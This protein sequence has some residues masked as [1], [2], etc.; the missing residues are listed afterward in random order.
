VTSDFPQEAP[1]IPQKI[2]INQYAF[3]GI[4]AVPPLP[5][6]LISLSPIIL[7]M[8]SPWKKTHQ[9]KLFGA[10][11]EMEFNLKQKTLLPFVQF[12]FSAGRWLK[13][14][15]HYYILYYI[16]LRFKEN[17]FL[18]KTQRLLGGHNQIIE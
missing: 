7:I 6:V 10:M 8:V 17:N 18:V 1:S 13:H 9:A 11:V 3:Q 15:Y 5:M 12:H 4:M 16:F 2:P 14:I